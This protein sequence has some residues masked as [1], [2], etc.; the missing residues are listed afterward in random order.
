MLLLEIR[1]SPRRS[2]S[3]DRNGLR[4]PTLVI[5][6]DAKQ[7]ARMFKVSRRITKLPTCTCSRTNIYR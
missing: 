2:S 6:L 5:A 4:E 7:L 3:R 1:D